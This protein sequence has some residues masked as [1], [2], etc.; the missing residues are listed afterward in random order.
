MTGRTSELIDELENMRFP[1]QS[2][3]L[4]VLEIQVEAIYNILK[5]NSE[6][7]H[8]A[9]ARITVLKDAVME[10]VSLVKNQEDRLYT[11]LKQVV[12]LTNKVGLL[13]I[14]LEETTSALNNLHGD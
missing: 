2:E 11:G 3:R 5:E 9:D 13:E 8:A 6:V 12:N 4:A 14:K 7:H 1:T 10:L